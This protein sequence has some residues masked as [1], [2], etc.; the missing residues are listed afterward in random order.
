[1]VYINIT[2]QQIAFIHRVVIG[3]RRFVGQSIDGF[4]VKVLCN[5]SLFSSLC[6]NDAS[7]IHVS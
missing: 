6:I 7:V 2:S 1:M 3:T 5:R 4:P